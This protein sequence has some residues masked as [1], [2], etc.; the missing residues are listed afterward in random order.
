MNEHDDGS[1]VVKT[2]LRGHGREY[3]REESIDCATLGIATDGW[4]ASGIRLLSAA[5]LKA[6]IPRDYIWC[7]NSTIKILSYFSEISEIINLRVDM[8]KAADL[9]IV[10][11]ALEDLN[12]PWFRRH[13]QA[14]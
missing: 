7:I 3:V 9:R 5:S 4:L 12:R 8:I 1:V 2:V 6:P 13:L 11:T 10:F 14:S